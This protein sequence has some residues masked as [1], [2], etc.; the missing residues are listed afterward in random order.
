MVTKLRLV[1]SIT[2]VFFSFYASGQSKYWEKVSA[3]N[4]KSRSSLRQLRVEKGAVFSFQENDFKQNLINVSSA[5][6]VSR[7]VYLPIL[8]A[9]R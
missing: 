9:R 6:S 2:I 4:F 8:W 7:I 3:S 1:F 5:K